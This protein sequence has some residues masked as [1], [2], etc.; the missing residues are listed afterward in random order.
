MST[1]AQLETRI[2]AR[3]VDASNV[4]YS[5]ATID[6]ALRSA[7]SDY[8]TVL[9][10]GSETYITLPGT[11]REIA[12]DALTGLIAVLD[13]WWP[14]NPDTEVWP[15]NMVAGFRVYWDDAR[16]VLLLASKN[17]N[18]PQINDSLRLW[19]TKPHTISSLDS[20]AT[21]TVFPNHE[22]M[23]VTGACAYCA[24]SEHMD[25]IGTVRVDPAEVPALQA[26]AAARM[27]EWQTWLARM[28]AAAP[29]F[30]PPFGD[31]WGIDKWDSSRSAT[32]S[33]PWT[34]T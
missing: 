7:L 10:L 22:S 33:R 14:Y 8:S 4:I 11:G 25:Q 26:W 31:G 20:A 32:Q 1:L 9:P 18:Q 30:G 13:V 6:E 15:P 19:Y 28:A 3:L 17:A 27:A 24:A 12:L 34:N 23:L 16:P 29:S 2:S 5:T 21:T